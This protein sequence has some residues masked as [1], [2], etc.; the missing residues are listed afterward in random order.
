MKQII[1]I[2]LINTS[3]FSYYGHGQENKILFDSIKKDPVNTWTFEHKLNRGLDSIIIFKTGIV[4][5][6]NQPIFTIT[7]LAEKRAA[8]SIIEAGRK[9]KYPNPFAPTTSSLNYSLGKKSLFTIT[10]F[11]T[12]CNEIIHLMNEELPKG[13]YNV[14]F[15]IYSILKPGVY[16]LEI[17]YLSQVQLRRL[18][19]RE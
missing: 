2:L 8:D 10:I 16:F 12:L 13:D 15:S 9:Q 17:K 14:N 18:I 7:T 5:T 1:L 6:T 19:V 3:L 11:D 4:T